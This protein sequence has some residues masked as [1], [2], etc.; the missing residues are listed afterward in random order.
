MN[1]PVSLALKVRQRAGYRCEFCRMSQSLQEASFHIEHILPR[2]HGGETA[3]PNLALACPG[4]NLHKAD[5]THAK[6]P[7]TGEIVS[8]FHPRKHSWGDHFEWV[9]FRLEGKSPEG[10]ATVALLKQNHP[11]RLLIRK[12]EHGFGLFPPD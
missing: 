9:A 3:L 7:G 4:C 2:V 10:G 5:R 11:R 6:N 1:V 8:L 12:A